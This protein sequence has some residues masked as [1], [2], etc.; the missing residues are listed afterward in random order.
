MRRVALLLATAAAA[1]A[2]PPAA[3]AALEV[4]LSI[5]PSAPRVGQHIRITMLT[6]APYLRVDGACCDLEPWDVG[7]YAFTLVATRPGGRSIPIRL[8]K[9]RKPVVWTAQF[10]FRRAGRWRLAVTNFQGCEHS[11]GARPCLSVR[12]RPRPRTT[13]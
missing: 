12:V 2:I 3:S 10:V 13:P 8:T 6:F 11:P 1:A 5:T 9:S 7:R 4:A